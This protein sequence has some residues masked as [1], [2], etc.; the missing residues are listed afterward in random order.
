[1]HVSCLESR[2]LNG[3]ELT[4]ANVS[5]KLVRCIVLATAVESLRLLANDMIDHLHL[6]GLIGTG[7]GMRDSNLDLQLDHILVG[8][9][10][11]TSHKATIVAIPHLSNRRSDRQLLDGA[12]LIDG[13]DNWLRAVRLDFSGRSSKVLHVLLQ[14]LGTLGFSRQRV[15]IVLELLRLLRRLPL[16]IRKGLTCSRKCLAQCSLERGAH[17]RNALDFSLGRSCGR[18]L[19]LDDLHAIQL[20]EL[21]L[22]L[23][24]LLGMLVLSSI[25]LE[26]I[27]RLLLLPERNVLAA[28]VDRIQLG[29]GTRA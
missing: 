29:L 11:R 5:D 9:L 17:A 8:I 21:G 12:Q 2:V 25:V 27:S 19:G 16:V 4:E 6:I 23:L 10:G 18:V 28:L 20:S 3:L 13:K 15:D 22:L 7:T 24:K 26:L 1:M 14:S